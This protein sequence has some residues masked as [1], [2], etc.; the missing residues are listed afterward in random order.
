MEAYINLNSAKSYDLRQALLVYSTDENSGEG[1]S[2]FVTK[3]DVK[4]GPNG[5]PSLQPGTT[6]ALEDIYDLVH[7]LR[8]SMP[9]EFLPENVL[10]RTQE[11]TVW[12]I[13][14]TVRPMFYAK[15]KNPE[16]AAISGKKFP[17]PALVFRVV[18]TQLDIRALATNERPT[19]KTCL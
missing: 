4:I 2:S 8:G 18:G 9:V 5:S 13:P 11:T 6:L 19:Q 14:A 15:K 12:W 1:P 16:L 17:Q 10:V 3:H 7:A